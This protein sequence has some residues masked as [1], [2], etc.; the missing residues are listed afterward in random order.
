[1]LIRLLDNYESGTGKAE[2]VTPEEER[3][4]REFIDACMETKML[5][6]RVPWYMLSY[7][8]Y[9]TLHMALLHSCFNII[10]TNVC[11]NIV[12]TPYIAVRVRGSYV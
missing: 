2:V 11:M 10:I 3:E 9:F 12:W 7:L 1:M 8:D 5:D 4:N 6:S